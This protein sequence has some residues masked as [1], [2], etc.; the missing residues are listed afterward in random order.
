MSTKLEKKNIKNLGWK[1]KL[2]TTKILTE[3]P[4]KNLEIK[5]KIT[6][7]KNIIYDKLQLRIKLKLITTFTK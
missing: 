1:V 2:K 3:E 4:R 6:K 7:L 5:R